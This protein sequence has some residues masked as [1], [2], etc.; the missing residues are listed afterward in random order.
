ME[1]NNLDLNNLYYSKLFLINRSNS[2]YDSIIR[3]ISFN[4]SDS[5]LKTPK[6][7]KP[8]EPYNNISINKSNNNNS[9]KNSINLNK[10]KNKNYPPKTFKELFVLIYFIQN[11]WDNNLR[12]YPKLSI[13]KNIKSKK[14][15]TPPYVCNLK[16]L[17]LNNRPR[18][19]VG[20]EAHDSRRYKAPSSS[21]GT[22]S[23][24][25]NENSNISIIKKKRSNISNTENEIEKY[26]VDYCENTELLNRILSVL[27]KSYSDSIISSDNESLELSDHIINCD[28]IS[29][30]YIYLASSSII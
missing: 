27:Q 22:Q 8:P 1:E 13:P 20:W 5:L 24:I 10:S 15:I 23:Y 2:K 3:N 4:L 25:D 21:Y 28:D 29:V 30:Y 16:S 17:K 12:N 9:I 26:S 6:I 7:L 19:F 14:P 11:K 18:D